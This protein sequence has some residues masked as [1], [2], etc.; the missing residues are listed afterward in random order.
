MG[1]LGVSDQQQYVII[2]ILMQNSTMI[3][4]TVMDFYKYSCIIHLILY[5]YGYVN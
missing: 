4:S 1:V 5:T 2:G 3:R